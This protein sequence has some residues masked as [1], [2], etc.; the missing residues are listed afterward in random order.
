MDEDEDPEFPSI[1][2]VVKT[3]SPIPGGCKPIDTIMLAEFS[4]ALPLARVAATLLREIS[5]VILCKHTRSHEGVI[6]L[7]FLQITNSAF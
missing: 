6:E 1:A 3:V 4:G 2:R 7:I 5:I